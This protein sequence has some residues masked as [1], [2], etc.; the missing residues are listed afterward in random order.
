M[1]TND[2]EPR[3]N[4]LFFDPDKHREGTG[5]AFDEFTKAFELRYNAQYPDPP[6][7]SLDAA[8]NRWKITNTTPDVAEPKPTLPQYDAL[9]SDWKEKDRVAKFLGMFTSQRLY[10]D[11]TVAQPDE[12]ARDGFHMDVFQRKN[13]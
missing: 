10:S 4:Q 9:V 8:I 5:K 11:W 2:N 6:K 7:V 1:S 13:A 3:S 12:A